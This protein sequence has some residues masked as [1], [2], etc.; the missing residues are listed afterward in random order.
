MSI[1]ISSIIIVII[2]FI[3]E[4]KIIDI[5]FLIVTIYIKNFYSRKILIARSFS[6][7]FDYC[8]YLYEKKYFDN[9][10]NIIVT[11]LLHANATG[12]RC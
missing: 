2:L 11:P 6:F 9:L 10:K 8:T 5:K 4:K 12:L 7:R 3:K 1:L